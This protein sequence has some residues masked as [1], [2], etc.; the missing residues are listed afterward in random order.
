MTSLK[1]FYL[2]F[3]LAASPSPDPVQQPIAIERP[4]VRKPLACAHVH[5]KRAAV[6]VLPQDS[7]SERAGILLPAILLKCHACTCTCYLCDQ[8]RWSAKHSL[9]QQHHRRRHLQPKLLLTSAERHCPRSSV[10]APQNQLQSRQTE[11]RWQ[12]P[13]PS[14]RRL[15]QCRL[16]GSCLIPRWLPVLEPFRS[17][18]FTRHFGQ[19][20]LMVRTLFATERRAM[21]PLASR[22][23]AVGK[24]LASRWQAVGKPLASRWQAVGKPLASRW[25]AVDQQSLDLQHFDFGCSFLHTLTVRKAKPIFKPLF[26]RLKR[27][28][29][30]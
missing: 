15:S 6:N 27:I 16:L 14:A 25:Q 21:L 23:Q 13:P 26:H 7:N 28:L 5:C 18:P 8:P 2:V 17:T 30:V 10:S 20:S 22:W 11:P 29:S 9:Q 4:S 24:P 19:T 12:H 1:R 3:S